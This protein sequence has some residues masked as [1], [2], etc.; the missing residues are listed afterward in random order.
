MAKSIQ[1]MK[2]NVFGKRFSVV[3]KNGETR[4]PFYLYEHTTTLHP[5][6]GYAVEHRRM[7]SRYQNFESCL[8]DLLD[9][10]VPEFRKDVFSA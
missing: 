1:M 5:E 2:M 10:K 4:N 6:Y 8:Y 9:M 7:V 3:F